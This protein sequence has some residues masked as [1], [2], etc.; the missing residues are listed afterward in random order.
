VQADDPRK[1]TGARDMRVALVTSPTRLALIQTLRGS[2]T[3]A[4]SRGS[5]NGD[6]SSGI[7]VKKGKATAKDWQI[8]SSNGG[9]VF[10][11]AQLE[12]QLRA[13]RI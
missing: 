5:L 4:G 13:Q 3:A 2:C 12:R 9:V 8:Y 6:P 7:L 11:A 10:D 1:D